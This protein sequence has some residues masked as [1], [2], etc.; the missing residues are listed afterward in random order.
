MEVLPEYRNRGVG[1]ELL[2]RMFATL[3]GIPNIDLTCDPELQ[4]Y[5][6]R[7]GMQP[8]VGMI[9]RNAP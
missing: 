6:Q 2:R 9:V 3:E 5:Y 1:S 4:R 7:F 8:V